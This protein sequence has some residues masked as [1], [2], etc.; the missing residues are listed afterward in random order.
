MLSEPNCVFCRIIRGEI[1]ATVIHRGEACLAFLDIQ[2]LASGHTLVV[3]TQHYPT[4]DRMPEQLAGEVAAALP[5]LGSAVMRAV[6]AT[7]FNVLINNGSDAGQVVPHLHIHL[8]P[9][10]AGD[11][12]GF[13]WNVRGYQPGEADR[14]AESLRRE[15]AG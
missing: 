10:R 2:P 3:P 12:L 5:R 14:V 4:L 9:R 11:G 6:G 8:I 13:R 15:L 7:G 1:P